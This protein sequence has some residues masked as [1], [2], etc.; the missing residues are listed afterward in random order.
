MR[1]AG[2]RAGGNLFYTRLIGHGIDADAMG[3]ATLNDWLNDTN[4]AYEIGRR[5][6]ADVVLIGTSMG[7]ALATW[8]AEKRRDAPP[9]AMILMSPA[10]AAKDAKRQQDLIQMVYLPWGE[11]IIR[12]MTG[13]YLGRA[14]IDDELEW[15]TSRMRPDAYVTIG[16][17]FELV[18]PIDLGAIESPVFIAYSKEDRAVEQDT[19]VDRFQR[20]SATYKTLLEVKETGDP[21]YHLLAGKYRSPQTT[22]GMVEAI[23][24]FLK[25]IKE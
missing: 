19:T 15:R 25:K 24:A 11:Q 6:G 22:A 8:L 3:E 13:G 5:L 7:G 2:D 17:V 23:Q 14:P 4:E 12:L 21:A 10:Y 1:L 16:A 18:D 9:L 20:F